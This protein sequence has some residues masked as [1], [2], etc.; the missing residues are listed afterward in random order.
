MFV[1][2]IQDPGSEQA[3]RITTAVAREA[4]VRRMR[5]VLADAIQDVLADEGDDFGLKQLRGDLPT[6]T[7]AQLSD[8]LNT[9]FGLR[10]TLV[11]SQP[12][13]A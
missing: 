1:L 11:D 8:T 6:M 4:L 5:A 9:R 10:V 12:L 13:L 2:I 3:P 7:E